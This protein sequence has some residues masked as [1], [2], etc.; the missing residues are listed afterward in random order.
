MSC[1]ST[2]VTR[3][4]IYE[5]FHHQVSMWEDNFKVDGT[6]NSIASSPMLMMKSSMDNKVKDT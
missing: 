3:M 4:D 6:L 1:S 5:P 2:Q